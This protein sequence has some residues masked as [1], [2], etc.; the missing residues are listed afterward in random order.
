ME[1]TKKEDRLFYLYSLLNES[2]SMPV[3]PNG[4]KEWVEIFC[5]KGVDF[6]ITPDEE[7]VKDCVERLLDD[8]RFN[9]FIL[10]LY[11]REILTDKHIKEFFSDLH[12]RSSSFGDWQKYAK[13]NWEVCLNND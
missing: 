10:W 5:E 13:K 6:I 2:W 12:F 1:N 3:H 4:F 8:E 7:E 9:T 11:D